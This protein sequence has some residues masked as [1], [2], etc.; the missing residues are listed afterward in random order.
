[1]IKKIIFPFYNNSKHNFLIN[2]WWFRTVLVIYIIV[3]SCSVLFQLNRY[4]GYRL[5]QLQIKNSYT[6]EELIK[7]GGKPVE[8]TSGSPAFERLK[9]KAMSAPI[10]EQPQQEG[11]LKLIIKAIII[12]LVI[13]YLF[14]LIFFKIVINFI[15]LY[16]KVGNSS[17]SE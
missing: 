17:S 16:R 7:M 14:Q 10:T 15:V 1:M 13:H 4:V 5:E 11:L 8:T 12:I 9:Q 2:K 6:Y 3:L